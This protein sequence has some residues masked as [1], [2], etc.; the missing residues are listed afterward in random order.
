V[1][2]VDDEFPREVDCHSRAS[3]RGRAP[4]SSS[5]EAHKKAERGGDDTERERNAAMKIRDFYAR[6]P[7]TYS[8]EMFPPKTDRGVLKLYATIAEL[9]T[10]GPSFISV[11]FAN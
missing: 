9:K 10:L 11:T 8:L 2:E 7:P 3:G 1:D 6:S 5:A 4:A